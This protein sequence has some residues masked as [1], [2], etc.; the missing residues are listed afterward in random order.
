M[1]E[2]E[3][4]EQERTLYRATLRNVR[5][6][7]RKARLVVDL[8]RGKNVVQALGILD[9]VTK[10]SSPVVKT[11]LKSA[12]ANAQFHREDVEVD[13]LTVRQAYVDAGRTLKRWRPRAMGRATPIRKRSAHITLAVG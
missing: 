4:D 6:S 11:L 12:I 13:S 1:A 5:I 3:R 9:A 7:P 2:Q 8:I 10:R